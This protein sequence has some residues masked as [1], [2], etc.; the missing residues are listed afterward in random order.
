[1]TELIPA[2]TEAYRSGGNFTQVYLDVSVDT[3]DPPQVKGERRTSLVD[4]LTRDGAPKEDIDCVLE[5][6]ETENHVP[7][8]VTVFA[9][10]KDG[11]AVIH[12]LLPGIPIGGEVVYHGPV[13]NLVPLV[14][15]QPGA[16]RYAVVETARDGGE[17]RLYRAGSFGQESEEHVQGRTD[18]LHKPREGGWSNDRYQDHA[19]EIW[20]RTQAELADVVNEV[21][22]TRKPS[23]LIVAGDIRAR[24][25]LQGELSEE[26]LSILS[27]V[28]VDTRADGASDEAL[29][30]HT[31][32]AIEEL[33]EAEKKKVI[34]LVNTH[35]GR[36]DNEM[37]D[38]VGEVVHALASAQVDTLLMDTNALADRTLLAL[39]GEPWIASAPEDALNAPVLAKVP[40]AVALLRAALL[41]DAH[42]LFTDSVTAPEG[43]DAVTLPTDSGVVALLR[44]RTGPGVPGVSADETPADDALAAGADQSHTGES[45][46]GETTGG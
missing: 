34:D 17:V 8:P 29:V 45:N 41:T 6:L 30:E 10:V 43:A 27:L 15:Q 2:A 5:I 21:V 18:T 28:P 20:R 31:K 24:Q 36:G 4:T 11:S 46:T 14:K 23:L 35:G 39:G 9:L 13:P 25:L 1:M 12:E 16:L 33:L 44:W 40:A 42:V 19:E 26:S 37:A 22:R 7:S 3:S 32:T 38:N